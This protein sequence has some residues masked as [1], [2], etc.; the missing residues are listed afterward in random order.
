MRRR[1]GQHY[2]WRDVLFLL[3]AALLAAVAVDKQ[4]KTDPTPEQAH[5]EVRVE[6]HWPDNDA[7]GAADDVDLWV[8]CPDDRPVG[9]SNR[10]AGA[11]TLDRD[12]LGSTYDA[13]P[14]NYETARSRGVTPGEYVIDAHLFA[15]RSAALPVPLTVAVYVTAPGTTVTSQVLVQT[16]ELRA[17]REEIT[18]VRF[19]L[20]AAGNVV[21]GSV[22]HAFRALR[23]AS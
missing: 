23:G 21:P 9:Y 13:T 18:V 3:V 17:E 7:A 6:M 20:D 12:D 1:D 15:H 14:Y 19:A 8:Q 10:T 11:C 16:A 4:A 2:A 22:N 5:G